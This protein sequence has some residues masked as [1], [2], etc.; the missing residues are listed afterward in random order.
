ML[1]I[2]LLELVLVLCAKLIVL[3]QFSAL[4]QLCAS[5][6]GIVRA[7]GFKTGREDYYW[8]KKYWN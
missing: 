3:F 6:D 7:I 2:R 4:K 1:P 8:R 5:H